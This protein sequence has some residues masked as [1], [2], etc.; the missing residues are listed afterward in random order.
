MTLTLDL[1]LP[2]LSHRHHQRRRHL[3]HPYIEASAVFSEC[4]RYRYRL[5]RRW[6]DGPTLMFIQLNPSTAD[7][8]RD[9]ATVRRDV[10]FATDFGYSGFE[11][12]N[13][14]A[15]RS[16]DPKQLG[17][18][19]DPIG[20]DNDAYLERAAAKHDLIVFAW[21]RHADPARARAVASRVW[22]ICSQIGGSV[23]CFGWTANGQPKHPLRLPA[24]TPLQTLTAGA[25]P[26]FIDVD[27]RWTQLLADTRDTTQG[28]GDD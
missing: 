12:L 3:H 22:H 11:A 15:G 19:G 10:G 20:P 5:T 13:I 18:F 9:D 2:Q 25:H 1:H 8:K 17:A 7:A 23:A 27:P 21:G 6:D 4:G 24:D 16:T 26:N 14:Y 28:V